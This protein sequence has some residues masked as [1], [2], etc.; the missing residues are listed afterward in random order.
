MFLYR[1]ETFV[2]TEDN[3]WEEHCCLILFLFSF[4]SVQGRIVFLIGDI[5][6]KKN[7]AF[8]SQDFLSLC[9]RLFSKDTDLLC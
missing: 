6:R 2:L 3:E 1:E 5:G 7:S 4:L 8:F 9:G